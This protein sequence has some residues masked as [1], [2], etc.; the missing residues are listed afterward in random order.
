MWFL[1]STAFMS[2][3]LDSIHYPWWT[4]LTAQSVCTGLSLPQQH[5]LPNA[6]ISLFFWGEGGG[7]FCFYLAEQ[8]LCLQ[9]L[10]LAKQTR[11]ETNNTKQGQVLLEAMLGASRKRFCSKEYLEQGTLNRCSNDLPLLSSPR[12]R[13]NMRRVRRTLRDVFCK[14]MSWRYTKTDNTF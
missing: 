6:S 13:S 5:F 7:A 9:T 11:S 3:S 14:Q 1:D 4:I 10:R 12:Y 8:P 2:L